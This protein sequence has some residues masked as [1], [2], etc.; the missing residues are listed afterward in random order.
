MT[1]ANKFFLPVL[2]SLI[3]LLPLAVQAEEQPPRLA[4][5]WTML[6]KADQSSD[7]FKGLEEHMKFRMEAGDPQTWK[8]YTP[9]LGD[10][11]GLVAVRACCMNW[12]DGDSY[13]EWGQQ[14]PEVNKHFNEHVAPYV[15]SYGH[16]FDEISWVNSNTKGDWSKFRFF[17]V[18]QFKL[19]VGMAGKFDAARD[20]ISQ[21][22]LNQGWATEE[23]PW[24][25]SSRVGGSPAESIVV[26]HE[27]MAS[28]DRDKQNFFNFMSKAL[29]SDEAAEELF[30]ELGSAVAEQEFQIWELHED[31]S[32]QQ[33]D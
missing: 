7:F 20:K 16:Y 15:E 2:V 12:A 23:R 1:K 22:A 4:E 17:A 25:W 21:I 32:M 11:L 26:P 31:V 28:M 3:M 24:I 10:D 9:M 13:R 29:G 8:T 19:K 30:G 33:S 5:M 27:N 14:N 6:P 18:T